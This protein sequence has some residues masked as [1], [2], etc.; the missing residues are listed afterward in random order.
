MF[1]HFWS[2]S[3]LESGSLEAA[4]K[5]KIIESHSGTFFDFKNIWFSGIPEGGEKKPVSS[6]T[7][8]KNMLPPQFLTQDTFLFKRVRAQL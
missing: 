8:L 7:Y 5:W 2:Q 4:W 6:I 1:L 3:Q